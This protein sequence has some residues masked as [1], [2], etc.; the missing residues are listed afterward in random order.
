MFARDRDGESTCSH[1]ELRIEIAQMVLH[2]RLGDRQPARDELVGSALT[3]QMKN[4]PLTF[5]E[6]RAGRANR[7]SSLKGLRNCSTPTMRLLHLPC[8]WRR[9]M[10]LRPASRSTSAAKPSATHYHM[11]LEGQPAPDVGRAVNSLY[12][13]DL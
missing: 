7:H 9:S 5:V 13:E 4:L 1:A 11:N 8:H 3:Q 2:C 12:R 10:R 6:Q